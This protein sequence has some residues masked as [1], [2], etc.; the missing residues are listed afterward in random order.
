MNCAE[1]RCARAGGGMCLQEG[2]VSHLVIFVWHPLI[3]KD[4]R[5]DA[6][7]LLIHR[8]EVIG[9]FYGCLALVFLVFS[10]VSLFSD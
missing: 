7:C 8:V 10:H 1:V 2:V 3:M 4:G 9:D 6:W 5:M